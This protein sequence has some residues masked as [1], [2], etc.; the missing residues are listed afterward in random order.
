MTALYFI[1]ALPLALRA[2]AGT[3]AWLTRRGDGPGV[4]VLGHRRVDRSMILT[5]LVLLTSEVV[6]SLAA[7]VLLAGVWS[8][9][10]IAP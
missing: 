9:V 1:L 8:A 2:G 10:M 7:S 5:T 6:L 3:F 4:R